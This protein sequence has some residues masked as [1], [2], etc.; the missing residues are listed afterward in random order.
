MTGAG[1]PVALQ[2]SG[3]SVAKSASTISLP[4]GK[5]IVAGSTIRPIMYKMFNKF[6]VSKQLIN[7][8]KSMECDNFH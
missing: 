5:V 2:V 4:L 7:V 8:Q 6:A 3:S 1:T